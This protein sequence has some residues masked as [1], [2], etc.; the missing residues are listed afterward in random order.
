MSNFDANKAIEEG[1][2]DVEAMLSGTM[3]SPVAEGTDAAT[4]KAVDAS[5]SDDMDT[6]IANAKNWNVTNL[7]YLKEG[8]A[9]VYK[10]EADGKVYGKVKDP[11]AQLKKFKEATGYVVDET[12]KVQFKALMVGDGAAYNAAM[13]II[14]QLEEAVKNP[15]KLFEAYVS[16]SKPAL[17]GVKLKKGATQEPVVLN[18]EECITE[19]LDHSVG[20]VFLV[21]NAAQ[22]E[23][24]ATSS[25]NKSKGGVATTTATK[26]GALQLRLNASDASATAGM[27]MYIR[28]VDD[29]KFEYKK[30]GRSALCVKYNK[31]TFGQD[32]Q[33][34]A[35]KK[36][37]DASKL[38]VMTYR[39]PL[40]VPQYEL[41]DDTELIVKFPIRTSGEMM[42]LTTKEGQ[43]KLAQEFKTLLGE[44][45]NTDILK[46][47]DIGKK[48][49]M[50]KGAVQAQAAEA[51]GAAID[52]LE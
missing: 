23:V 46:K 28:T 1:A 38:K 48:I 4:Q 10:Q 19:V 12:G 31:G 8:P 47:T 35:E 40:E 5:V 50:A 42:N 44:A 15:D 45:L 26:K 34:I 18:K 30:G 16:K 25:R 11:E 52:D 27:A 32:G 17:K 13:D 22:L 7:I 21:G 49:S 24:K 20:K 9:K 36:K 37:D 6:R 51:A 39:I 29:S 2:A 33:W 14:A 3:G 43:E 41:V